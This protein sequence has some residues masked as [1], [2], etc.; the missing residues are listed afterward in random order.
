MH[1]APL[2]TQEATPLDLGWTEGD[3]ISLS[4][5]AVG[6]DWSAGSY[7]AEVKAAQDASADALLTLTVTAELAENGEDTIFTLTAD[8]SS[9]APHGAR[10]YWDLQEVDGVT[11]F[12]GRCHVGPQVTG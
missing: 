4:F 11:R 10:L 12:S 9:G 7:V 3:P 8:D 2:L 5:T 1:I 6:V